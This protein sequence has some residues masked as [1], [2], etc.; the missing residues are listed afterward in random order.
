MS[1]S[2]QVP[3]GTV[4][5]IQGRATVIPAGEGAARLLKV[6]DTIQTG[7]AV[8]TSA[9]TQLQIT[10]PQGNPWAPRDL[11]LAL[12]QA[13]ASPV[14][15]G[16]QSK[17]LHAK[18][19]A[20]T[21]EKETSGK[22]TDQAIQAIEQGDKDAAPAAGVDGGGNG[23]M[24]PGLR[25]DR[26]IEVV[27]T[28]EFAFGTTERIGGGTTEAAPA[29]AVQDTAIADAVAKLAAADDTF[30]T[31]K[32]V[33]V[34][35]PVLSNDTIETGSGAQ[36]VAINGQA[37]LPGGQIVVEHGLVQM[38]STG[39]LT[40][41]P[42]DGYTGTQAF[43]YTVTNASGQT[44]DASVTVN[45]VNGSNVPV[46][47]PDLL[48]TKEDTPVTF[49]VTG[50]DEPG[51]AGPI[52]ITAINGQSLVAGDTIAVSHGSVTLNADG[53]LTIT[54][55]LNYAGDIG[56]AYTVTDQAGQSA[57]STVQ[58]QVEAINDAPLVSGGTLVDV[59]TAEDAPVS[60]KVNATDPEDDA[61]TFTQG[62][63]PAHG[64]ATVNGD[65]T[66]TYTPKP[67]FNGKDSFTVTVSDGNGGSTEVTIRVDVADVPD[68][69]RVGSPSDPT[70][71]AGSGNY[72]VTTNEDQ[73]A[74]GQVT[75]QDPDG[76]P[77]T[78][79]KG[80]DPTHGS[81]T[82]NPD[83]SWTYTP[84]KDYNGPDS[85]TVT[86]SDDNGHST[87]TTINVGVIAAPDSA[88]FDSTGTQ[89]AVTEDAAVNG[90]G[91]LTTGG[92][93][94]AVDPD[95]GTSTFQPQSGTQGAYGS[96]ELNA[97]GTWTYTAAN[98]NPA[99][100]ALGNGDTLTE[101]FTVKAA[102]GTPATVTI[103][104][105]GS[106]DSAVISSSGTTGSVTE[107]AGVNGA[108]NLVANGTLSVTDTDAGQA[109]FQAGTTHGAYGDLALNA[110]GT[111]TY[112]AA[113]GNP[114]I[115][116]LGN[117]DTLTETFTVKA[118]D[119]TSATVTITINGSNDSAVISSSG[120]TGSVTEDAGVNGA[121]N[122]V[123][124]G[125][126]SV[127]DTDAGQACFQ[128]GTTHGA[129]GD[130]ALNADGTWTYTAANS[131]PAI[132]ALGN[133]D[134]LT[135]TF[136][137]KSTDGTSATVTITI[138]GSND[139]AVISSS[140]TTGSVNE[141]SNVD[142]S[143]NLVVNGTLSVTDTDAG[144]A[145]FQAGT[146]H[147]AYGDL[148]LNAD[149]TW[150]FTAA[151]GNPAI[152]ALGNGNTLTETFT[153][154]AADGTPT[155]VTITINGANDSAVISS[156]GTTGSVTEDAGV[157]GAGNLVANG[158]LSVTD[159]DLGQAGF[160][161]QTNKAGLYG[162][163]NLA[164]NGAWTYSANNGQTAIQQLGAGQTLT[165]TFSV[166]SIDGT[167][168]SVTVTIHGT[169]DSAVLV[170][171]IP[172][173]TVTEDT[174]VNA[175]KLTTGGTVVMSDIDLGQVG[176]QPQTNFAGTYG[177]FSITAGGSWT[178]SANNSQQAIQQ[179]G[180]GQSLTESFT[181]RSFD[182]TP[183]TVKIT[184]MGVNDAAVIS[185]SG[186]TG[187][188]TE[189]QSVSGGN[190]ITN[191]KL[192]VTDT[193]LGE[194]TFQAQ[195]NTAGK[196]GTFNLGTD[197]NWT[198]SANNGQSAIQQL[199]AGQSLSETFTV[200]AYD[201]TSSTVTVTIN[202]TNDTPT[203][204]CNTGSAQRYVEDTL[205][206]QIFNQPITI[207]DPDSSDLMGATIKL[208]N[209]QVGDI[210]WFGIMPLGILPI[211]YNPLT[212]ELTLIGKASVADYQAA[213]QSIYFSTPGH[214]PVDTDRQITLTVTDGQGTSNTISTTMGI[215]LVNDSFVPTLSV[216]PVGHWTFD[217]AI[218]S[219]TT[220]NRNNIAQVGSLAD[221]SSTG[222]IGLPTF[223]SVGQRSAASGNYISFN[224]AGDRINI[225]TSV[226][227][228]L[229]GTA[230]MTFWLKTSMTGSGGGN[231][232]SWDLASIIG[233]EQNGGGNDIQW[234]AI[235]S[236]GKI[237]FG[238]GNV[239]GVFSTTSINDNVWH[240]VAITRNASTGLVQVFVDGKL[241]A[242]GS[243]TDS[244]YTGLLN[245]LTSMG[246]T[247]QFSNNAS[248]S[249]MADKNYYTGQLD[250]LHIY[251]R[252]LTADQIK[253]IRTVENG[254]QDHAIANDGGALKIAVG[255]SLYDHLTVTGLES[256]MTISDG[257][258]T[259]TSTGNGQSIDLTGWTLSALQITNAG[260]ASA[261]LAFNATSTALNGETHTTTD[262]LN[263]VNGSTIVTGTSGD[264]MVAATSTGASFLAGGA[265]Q[266]NVVGNAGNDRLLGE[267]GDDNLTGLGGHD[268]LVGGA[269][270][271]LLT[272]GA[273][274][275][276][277]RWE[278]NDGGAKNSPSV[279]YIS[280]FS[281][282]PGN[283][284]VLDLRDLLQGDNHVGTNSGN[285]SNYMHFEYNGADTV[286][287]LSSNGGF[288][289]GYTHAQEDQ[290]IVLRSV[291]LTL[292]GALTN[293]QQIIKDLL[294]KGQLNV[295]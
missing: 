156:S 14:P 20:L 234:G 232:N 289:A 141:D 139:S 6:G 122:L 81:V 173:G 255:G 263:I 201:G 136:T 240:N 213:I 154:K 102:D 137:V 249:D 231:G 290:T 24:T 57:N 151:N 166:K 112:T 152:Q 49:L 60:G 75:A 280:D 54:P 110:D 40:F 66:W 168:S 98:G 21:G 295:D 149:G 225:S 221:D 103:T 215:A 220:Y 72:N 132:Q 235:N 236:A 44:A 18:V 80:S 120:T 223:S 277:F 197:G 131:N 148:A 134:T 230:T 73:P 107:D 170:P 271:D 10:D 64:S 265:G 78:F 27:G 175:G 279:D 253:A 260:T 183:A 193:D 70:F 37:I 114:A 118:A 162:T 146:T 11:L 1:K 15:A 247:N 209:P 93:L 169:N 182:G 79:G 100:Q 124:N 133:G 177:S 84:A 208:T 8:L 86:V 9:G 238:L 99:I 274:N 275:D 113:N 76:D 158:T 130:L 161:T 226:T 126:L 52:Q 62:T 239:A 160:Q 278:L 63:G 187:S 227:Q 117:G 217:D 2:A 262:Y 105:N 212:G 12:A 94:V 87:T 286:I 5:S 205:P 257:V 32:G 83:G 287:H 165:E 29:A 16:K 129:Y 144:Q 218:G 194:S 243:P 41:A 283:K 294:T 252:V 7:D 178:Y 248:G 155:T 101:T 71:D 172:V 273:G 121:G 186:T 282:T 244:A 251:D 145:G 237:G 281:S 92:K 67:D 46:P 191:G 171:T 39:A 116:A 140:G 34:G 293:D 13:N 272:G 199:G 128:A 85:F 206:V 276:V 17:S 229:M 90:S 192:T 164:A 190:L 224:D 88:V 270:N 245:R 228:P 291:D 211:A 142:A 69:P 108:G 233:S 74:N 115:Q 30:T 222:G 96:F 91:Q 55:E 207:T 59:N 22:E 43:T 284:D 33:A 196:Y 135:E 45:V 198:Y 119:G 288:N 143:G 203:L 47:S 25:V 219:I 285:L 181:V 250:D 159:T 50:N 195:T 125:T 202:G 42:A 268:V 261:T 157:N 254:Y 109:G 189:D 23:S 242:T 53:T 26:V 68:A 184:I 174:N 138:N 3:G 147:G 167:T 65:G 104:I 31:N 292:G 267:S 180:N 266:D 19:K 89:G 28:Q 111:W 77:V 214:S 56:F 188:V 216:A 153:V 97:D 204:S 48:L 210:L 35:L 106:N 200:K 163:F 150:T 269:G 264:D 127:T 95:S 82:V 51:S 36:V 241:E 176:F 4:T 38:T 258:H 123:V 185:S 246:A 179:L 58:V 256:G 259:A 61:L